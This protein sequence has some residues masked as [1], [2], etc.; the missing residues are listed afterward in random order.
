[1]LALVPEI[2]APVVAPV[3]ER[4]PLTLKTSTW[5][6]P[7]GGARQGGDW[8]DAHAL[9]DTQTA[10]A[11]FDVAGHGEAAAATMQALRSVFF[12]AMRSGVCPSAIVALAN[13]VACSRK[14]GLIVTALVGILD[15]RRREFSF[16]SAGNPAPLLM[17]ATGHA[18]CSKKV[19]DLPLGIFRKCDVELQ[20]VPVPEDA[21]L[22]LCTD[23][24][25]EHGRDGARGEI[26]LVETCRGLYDLPI[27]HAARTI[28]HNVL[29]SGRGH[30]DVALI[31]VRTA[32]SRRR[33]VSAA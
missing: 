25:T 13:A 6:A 1:M 2:V 21:L 23:G 5:G 30:D 7:A 8:C 10:L 14:E 17:T 33:R 29:S 32:V 11:I 28:A 26:E 19:G 20:R 12:V 3:Y 16:A 24:L 27:L 9:S 4:T 22:V 31:A 18:F 15:G